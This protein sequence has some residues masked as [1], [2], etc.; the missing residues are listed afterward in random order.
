MKRWSLFVG[1][2]AVLAVAA[3]GLSASASA[4]EQA[5]DQQ[6]PTGRLVIAV[7]GDP[8]GLD[9][10]T[11]YIFG[12]EVAANIYSFLV[13]NGVNYARNSYVPT[14]HASDLVQSWSVSRRDNTITLRLNPRATF[15]DGAPVTAEDVRYTLQRGLQGNLGFTKI[16]YAVGNLASMRQVQVVNSRTIRL[17]YPQGLNRF[18]LANLTH[19]LFGVVKKTYVE[20]GATSAD[21]WGGRLLAQK[22][23]GSGPYT[24]ASWRPGESVL[25]RA[26]SGYWGQPKPTYAEIEYRIIPNSQTRALLLRSGEVDVAYDLSPEQLRQAASEAD[27]RVLSVPAPQDTLA[28]RMNPAEAPFDDLNF[29]RAIIKAIPYGEI[30]RGAVRGFGTR[31]KSPC[32]ISAQGYRSYSLYETNLRQARAFL[33]RSKYAS[34]ARFTL[35]LPNANPSVVTAVQMIQSS[36]RRIGITMDIRALPA[37]AYN[38]QLQRSGAPVNVHAMSP[39]FN[40][41]LYWAYWMFTSNSPT[42]Y[43]RYSNR[44]LDRQVRAALNVAP[45]NTRRYNALINSV[46][47]NILV[48]DAV[49]APLYQ[50]HMTVAA[51]RNVDR[52]VFWPYRGIQWKYARPAR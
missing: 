50:V 16:Q 14:K 35:I 49:V 5:P 18:S 13:G 12:W 26:R 37:A 6:E 10:A 32:G 47:T 51:K 7:P 40:D 38:A 8:E 21:P 4:K 15:S 45:D 33:A 24:L 52:L 31:I 46:I 11:T 44:A 25:L 17:R 23:L 29:R 41:C 20:S 3:V 9:P 28:F 42:N 1:L 22:P 34:G 39:A 30:I 43:I 36:L 2:G 48:G 19:Q 27:L